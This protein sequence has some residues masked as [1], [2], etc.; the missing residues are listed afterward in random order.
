LEGA[1]IHLFR[2][3]HTYSSFSAWQTCLRRVCE[4]SFYLC[5][6]MNKLLNFPLLIII[7]IYQYVI[8]PFTPASCRHLPTCS[9]Y[10]VEA[11]NR[12][13]PVY[14]GK[15]AINRI[16]RCHPWGTSGFDPVPVVRIKRLKSC[17]AESSNRLKHHHHKNHLL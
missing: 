10:A 8:S 6:A 4:F 11:L 7:R 2:I 16:L 3:R 5:H 17:R 14:G 13:G 9:A 12:H 15:L 1:K